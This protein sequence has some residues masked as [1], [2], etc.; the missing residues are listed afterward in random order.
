LLKGVR[1]LEAA[2]LLMGDY[3]GMLL[4]DEGADVIKVE[5][6]GTDD[7]TR[8]FM[9][10]VAPHYSPYHPTA[11]ALAARIAELPPVQLALIREEIYKSL[12]LND[13]DASMKLEMFGLGVSQR[14]QDYH[15]GHRSVIEKRPP[16]FKG[17]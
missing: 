10:Q 9:G 4:A 16:E 7:Y 13:L 5:S 1:V 11:R 12:E 17:Y 2:V 6:P 14:T 8:E 15:E 3:F